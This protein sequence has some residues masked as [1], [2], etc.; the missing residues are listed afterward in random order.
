MYNCL[1][2][3]CRKTLK[4]LDVGGVLYATHLHVCTCISAQQEQEEKGAFICR[5]SVN[6]LDDNRN[7][8]AQDMG[9]CLMR[10]VKLFA[11]S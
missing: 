5:G 3:F 6:G 2:C 11:I 7:E 10:D 8:W 1:C 4:D 9:H